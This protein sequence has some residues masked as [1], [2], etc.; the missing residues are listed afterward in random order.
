MLTIIKNIS[1][2]IVIMAGAIFTDHA[3][4]FEY[5][6][7]AEYDSAI[8]TVEQVLGY[9]SGDEITSPEDMIRYFE[10]LEKASPARIKIFDYG[11][12][13]QGRRLIYAAISNEKNIEN[14]EILTRDMKRLADPRLTNQTTAND[15]IANIVG[16]T[17]LGHSV[18]GNEISPM[19]ASMMTAYHLLAA[20]N[21]SQVD[22]IMTNSVVFIDPMINPDGRARFIAS[23]R[24]A[25]GLEADNNSL[26][27]EHNEPWPSGRVNHYLFDL[28]RDWFALTQPESEARVK[29]LQEYFPLVFIDLHEMGGNS[30]YFFSPPAPPNNPNISDSQW[31]GLQLIGRNNAKYFDKYGFDYY[32][33][34]VFDAFYPGY[35]ASWPAYYGGLAAT[36][37]QA[38]AGGLVYHRKDGTDLHYRDTVRHHVVTSLST[39]EVV[40]THKQ[41][42]LNDFYTYRKSAIEEGQKE[43]NR[44]YIIPSQFDQA[45]A[46]KLSGLLTKQGVNITISEA[47]FRA[48]GITYAPGSYIIDSAQPAKR[49]IRTMMDENVDI[50][51]AFLEEQERR[52]DN[53]LGDQIYDVTAWSLPHLFNINVDRCNNVPSVKQSFAGTA[54]YAPGILN[55]PDAK[56]A[57]IVPWGQS[58]SS[59]F[60]SHALR[61]G[62]TVKSADIAFTNLGVTYPAGSLILDIASN[63]V[64][65]NEK[66]QNIAQETGANIY[67]VNDS[68]VT[69]GPSF[70]SENTVRIHAPKVGILWD[71][72]T[73]NYSAG[74]TRYVIERQ[75][76]YPVSAVRT[77]NII[78]ADLSQ[79]QVLIIPESR[80]SY[81]SVLGEAGA[82]NLKEWV[83]K[84]GTLIALGTAMR[85]V[86]DPD[87]NIMSSRREYAYRTKTND[88]KQDGA[89][90]EG[91]LIESDQDLQNIII[92]DKADP[93]VVPGVMLKAKVD[94]EHWLTAGSAAE[95]NVLYRG[96]DIYTPITIDKG[97]SV[98][99]FA[100]KED[101]LASGYLWQEN[102]EQLAHKPFII[103]EPKG[104]GQVIGFTADPTVRAYLD[105][106]NLMLIN[107]IF[108][109]SAHSSP[110]R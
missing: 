78:N 28:N 16:T 3:K 36:Y 94:L 66:L 103:S 109:G 25:R 51:P 104:K 14:L 11:K 70:G 89:K 10:A 18:H 65:L 99:S 13:W 34:E 4:A 77:A 41:K 38:S 43:D 92:A 100:A 33:R 6:P 67:G 21:Q 35:G 80:E 105:G 23:Y 61:Q 85:Y 40:A 57:F 20:T 93:D 42:L 69:N 48:C 76:D 19:E 88:P 15:I 74:N 84:G 75:F 108:R 107:A 26:S 72:P 55:N 101:L 24:S 87:V 60:L 32:T 81:K 62:L 49:F 27:A 50:D 1:W 86:T 106:L 82:N 91:R 39:A 97:R 71:T 46:D 37:E 95:L 110:L 29:I 5:I 83:D 52:R 58:T 56:V 45:A 47:E 2:S 102:H 22:N 44:Y 30:S 90:T 63:D 7:G 98:A 68:W 59:R 9:K 53:N 54:Y 8:P 31:Q 17:W 73:A 96:N 64:G 12:T 79:Y